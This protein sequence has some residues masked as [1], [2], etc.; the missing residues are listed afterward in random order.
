M[1][2]GDEGTGLGDSVGMGDGDDGA[3]VGMPIHAGA[4]HSNT[5]IMHHSRKGRRISSHT[6]PSV[7]AR[8]I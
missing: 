1:G 6:S 5:S 7:F 3:R 4:L 2:D 8:M